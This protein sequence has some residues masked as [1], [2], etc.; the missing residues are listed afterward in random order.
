V[1][2]SPGPF[3]FKRVLLTNRESLIG[4]YSKQKLS[5]GL[6]RVAV[7]HNTPKLPHAS[8]CPLKTSESSSVQ[9]NRM[10]QKSV[11]QK[12]I[13]KMQT[14]KFTWRAPPEVPKIPVR[15]YTFSFC[16]QAHMFDP[17]DFSAVCRV[18]A[19]A[20]KT[21]QNTEK[22]ELPKNRRINVLSC[23]AAF[24]ALS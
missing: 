23:F 10:S 19:T 15:G 6:G 7:R 11:A 17:A 1:P 4:R 16:F 2:I 20:Q 14:Y 12:C 5:W 8:R 24:S 3:V 13:S 21:P 18:V 22:H 9:H